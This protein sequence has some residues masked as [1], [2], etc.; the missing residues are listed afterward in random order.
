LVA[1]GDGLP[2][3]VEVIPLASQ[4]QASGLGEETRKSPA[5]FAPQPDL[6]ALALHRP[7][8]TRDWSI[9]SRFIKLR[10]D[11]HRGPTKLGLSHRMGAVAYLNKGTVF[12]KRF[13]YA[14]GGHYPDGRLATSRRSPTRTCSRSRASGHSR[15]WSP[16]RRSSTSSAGSCLRR[17]GE[18][19][20]RGASPGEGPRESKARP[21]VQPPL[22]GDVRRTAGSRLRAAGRPA[23]AGRGMAS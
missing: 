5:D 10:Q 7:D 21:V 8:T 11:A 3:G 16:A 15:G 20:R 13:G 18:K 22:R 6:G 4:G 19:D 2:A 23:R 12:V 14:E 1:V 17:R 9:G